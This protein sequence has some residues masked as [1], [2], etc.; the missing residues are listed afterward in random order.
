MPVLTHGAKAAATALLLALAACGRAPAAN[1][2]VNA[3]PPAPPAPP[4]VDNM[5]ATSPAPAQSMGHI[6]EEP[7]TNEGSGPKNRFIVCPGN[8]RCPPDGGQPSGR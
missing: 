2:G 7:A 4:P 1:E 3:A 5:T 6:G 8:P